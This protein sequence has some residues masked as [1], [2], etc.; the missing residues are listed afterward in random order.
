M[1]PIQV[2]DFKSVSLA[3]KDISDGGALVSNLAPTAV[4]HF[5]GCGTGSTKNNRSDVSS[6]SIQPIKHPFAI[7]QFI[8]QSKIH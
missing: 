2:P 6:K 3:L 1:R 5:N 4:G 7:D 8:H